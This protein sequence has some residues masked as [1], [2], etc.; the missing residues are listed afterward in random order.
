MGTWSNATL[1]TTTSLAKIESEINELTSSG[2]KTYLAEAVD[3]DT[4]TDP[5]VTG[6]SAIDISD[7]KGSLEIWG[8]VN[9]TGAIASEH[10][11][12]I[13][14][15]DCATESGTF[16]E[17]DIG[18]RIY[19]RDIAATLTEDDVLFKWV[20][21]SHCE[22]WIQV[23]ISSSTSNSGKID[24]YAVAKWSNKI[25]LAKELLGEDMERSLMNENLDHFI[26]YADGED[27]KDI[28]FNPTIF[29]IASDYLTLSLIY[30]D[31]AN[32]DEDS[33]FYKK[34][35]NYRVKYERQFKKAYNLKNLDLDLDS[36]ADIY[37][38]KEV[39]APLLTR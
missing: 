18:Q 22:D 13:K 6:I 32:A 26:N 27:L 7:G 31:L 39:V 4:A 11:L 10:S 35:Q 37:K 9:T 36:D 21:P 5:I 34:S 12:R 16:V 33:I 19:Y 1:S 3:I 23:V 15:Y 25:S 30:E 29:S 14:I 17:I 20:V 2:A 28:V 24:I 8:V 38:S